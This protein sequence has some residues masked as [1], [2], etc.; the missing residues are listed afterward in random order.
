MMRGISIVYVLSRQFIP[1]VISDTVHSSRL[2]IHSLF[3][4]NNLLK[5][6]QPFREYDP[7]NFPALPGIQ[8]ALQQTG[9]YRTIKSFKTQFV[10][11]HNPGQMPEPS[12]IYAL[13]TALTT[14]KTCGIENC[15]QK[16]GSF[17]I[18]GKHRE[19]GIKLLLKIKSKGR[20][21]RVR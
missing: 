19:Q 11:L 10:Y 13:T 17:Y 21:E 7:F 6:L 3:F 15:R 2:L 5:N 8:E 18:E 9:R 4:I 20:M 1:A 16:P 14:R 12:I